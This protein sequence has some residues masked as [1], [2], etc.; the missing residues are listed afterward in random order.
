MSEQS[1]IDLETSSTPTN[2]GFQ[3][4]LDYIREAARSERQ[5]GELF[6]RLMLTYFSQ[7]PDYKQQF[8]EVYLLKTGRHSKQATTQTI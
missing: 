4:T 5:K 8:S 7:D 3:S 6:E 1:Y 2:P